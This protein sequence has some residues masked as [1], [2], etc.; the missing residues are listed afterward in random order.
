MTYLP[1]LVYSLPYPNNLTIGSPVWILHL[2]LNQTSITKLREPINIT[3]PHP[4]EV[5]SHMIVT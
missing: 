4:I 1:T 5:T 2:L 3:F